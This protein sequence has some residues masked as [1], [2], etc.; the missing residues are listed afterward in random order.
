MSSQSSTVKKANNFQII[1]ELPRKKQGVLSLLLLQR[2]LPN[3][4]LFVQVCDFPQPH[5]IDNML[6]SLWEALLVKGAKVN[7]SALENKLEELTPDEAEFDM[8]G[9]YPALYFCTGMLTYVSGESNEDEYDP[10]AIAKI[11]QGCIVHLIEYQADED[12]DNEFIRQHPLM[13]DEMAFLSDTLEWLTELNTKPS[14]YKAV[15]EQVNQRLLTAGVTNIGI[16]IE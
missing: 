8:Y 16:E 10:V 15:R 12:V 7:L 5:S 1:R 14:Q 11:S 13:Q 3:Y 2:M 6:N 4:Q 9:V